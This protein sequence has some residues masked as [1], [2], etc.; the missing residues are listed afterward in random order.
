MSSAVCTTRTIQITESLQN[1][2]NCSSEQ[3]LAVQEAQDII[4]NLA[5]KTY[6]PTVNTAFCM[7]VLLNTLASHIFCMCPQETFTYT[8]LELHILAKT[9]TLQPMA[10]VAGIIL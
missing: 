9:K 10:Q 2:M 5:R 8:I 1:G 3:K 6:S 4:K 7:C